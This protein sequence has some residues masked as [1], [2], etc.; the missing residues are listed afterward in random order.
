MSVREAPVRVNVVAVVIAVVILGFG[1]VA[2]VTAFA[3]L[4]LAA[5]RGSRRREPPAGTEPEGADHG[6]S[7]TGG[8]VPTRGHDAR[9]R[10]DDPPKHR[11]A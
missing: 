4:A 11:K 2:A 10:R 8:D 9:K 1:V 5:M 7:T 6:D 3:A